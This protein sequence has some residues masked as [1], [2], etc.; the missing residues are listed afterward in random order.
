MKSVTQC[1]SEGYKIFSKLAWL[2]VVPLV[3]DIL[4]MYERLVALPPNTVTY[5]VKFSF[6]VYL[7]SL[8]DVYNFPSVGSVQIGSAPISPSDPLAAILVAVLFTLLISFLAGGYLGTIAAKRGEMGPSPSFF[9]LCSKYF[10]RFFG[11]ALIWFALTL[12][13]LAFALSNALGLVFL[14]IL[15]LFLVNYF[16]FLT[17]FAIVVDGV[18]LRTALSKSVGMA[19]SRVGFVLPYVI[20]YAIFTALTSVVI[21]LFMNAGVGGYLLDAVLYAFVGTIFVSSTLVLYSEASASPA[22]SSSTVIETQTWSSSGQDSIGS[23]D[24]M[25]KTV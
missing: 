23:A 2:A 3:L 20:I 24:S 19:K 22:A 17:P 5:G 8:S 1:F 15:F 7:P 4:N 12:V 11:Y 18:S 10:V 25:N 14:Y 13:A 9:G 21:Y 16:L 6:P